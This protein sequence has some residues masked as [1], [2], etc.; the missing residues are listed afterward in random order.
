MDASLLQIIQ[1][2]NWVKGSWLESSQPI[3]SNIWFHS[4]IRDQL[5]SHD[6]LC[7]TGAEQVMWLDSCLW[8]VN[9]LLL[10]VG[11]VQVSFLW[12]H[13]PFGYL[14]ARMHQIKKIKMDSWK[15]NYF[16]TRETQDRIH[17][18]YIG[19]MICLN[20]H[21]YTHM[22]HTFYTCCQDRVLVYLQSQSQI[23]KLKRG[24]VTCNFLC[25]YVLYP[26]S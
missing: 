13:W 20:I 19:K 3:V 18:R 5:V 9:S 11:M 2:V 23:T 6:L 15:E 12:P 24:A 8:L 16:L 4:P 25:T 10:L 7:T 14:Q 1:K 26:L 21:Q 22:H 17:F